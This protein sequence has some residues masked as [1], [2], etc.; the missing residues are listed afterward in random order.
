MPELD[1]LHPLLVHFPIALYG[2]GLIFDIGGS[3]LHNEGLTKAGW[4]NMAAAQF[5]ALFTVISGFLADGLVGHMDNPFPIFKTH[6]SLQLLAILLLSILFFIRCRNKSK[7]PQSGRSLII[8]LT[9]HLVS[10]V[11]LFYGAHLGAR[12]ANR[13]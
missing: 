9:S 3:I 7:L 1:S 12:L 8:F 4:W 10:V 5:F 11:F 6:G 2:V 13:I